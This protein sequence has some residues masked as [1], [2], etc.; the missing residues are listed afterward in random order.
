MKKDQILCRSDLP[1]EEEEE[2]EKVI[3]ID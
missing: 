2:E 3:V 1:E